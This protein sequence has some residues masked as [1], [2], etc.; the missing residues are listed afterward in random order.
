MFT[1]S[2]RSIFPPVLG[3][4]IIIGLAAAIMSGADSLIMVAAASMSRDIYQRYFRP[5]ATSRQLLFYSRA[6]VSAFSC[7]GLIIA[8]TAGGIMPLLVLAFKTSG[9][10]LA[11]PFLA[12]MFWKSS[13]RAGVIGGMTAG[14]TVTTALQFFP[15][16]TQWP[17][18]W[19]YIA[20][21]ITIVGISLLTSHAEN[22]QV[23]AVF[24][25]GLDTGESLNFGAV[26]A[27]DTQ[28]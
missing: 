11:F 17:A 3:A 18:A 5:N 16:L 19:G 10:G 12:L 6:G 15:T 14:I 4:L 2:I 22:E 1:V 28:K 21:L 24:V 27:Q 8:L 9:A 7:L 26:A 20:S 13:T 25:H 23:R